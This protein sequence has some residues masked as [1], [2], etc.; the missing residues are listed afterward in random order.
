MA[1]AFH[2][3]SMP[4]GSVCYSAGVPSTSNPTTAAVLMPKGRVPPSRR[5]RLIPAT[6]RVIYLRSQRVRCGQ[7]AEGRRLLYAGSVLKR[8]AITLAFHAGIVDKNAAIS[9][10]WRR[11]RRDANQAC[12]FCERCV[13]ASED[14]GDTIA[15]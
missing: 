1:L 12:K 7:R 10:R 13:A 5:F 14:V 2:A 6:Y 9:T 15:K 3:L 8:Q 4:L 11:R